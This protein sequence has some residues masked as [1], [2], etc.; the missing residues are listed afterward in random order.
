MNNDTTVLT[1]FPHIGEH[2]MYCFNCKVVVCD[3]C[4]REHTENKHK[5]DDIYLVAN[6]YRDCINKN[7][8]TI[9]K[10]VSELIEY[11]R[12]YKIEVTAKISKDLEVIEEMLNTLLNEIDIKKENLKGCMKI[13]YQK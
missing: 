12:D 7:K 6:S 9:T 13:N 1:C 4:S 11:I 2:R 3:N 8:E 5:T 10:K